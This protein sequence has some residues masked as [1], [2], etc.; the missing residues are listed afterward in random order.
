MIEKFLNEF[1]IIKGIVQV[2]SNSGQEIDIMSK[3]TK[4]IMLFDPLS[5][6]NEK[7]RELYPSYK[8][9]DVALGSENKDS[10]LYVA[11]NQGESSS[12]LKP[13]KHVDFYPQITFDK[14]INISIKKFKTIIDDEKI[15]V[16]KYN[17][18]ISDTQGYDLEVLKGF[19]DYIN[20]FNLIILEYINSELYENNASLDDIKNYLS[21]I[22]FNLVSTFDENL[23]AG[24]A[25]FIKK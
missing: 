22:G 8:I 7:L 24:N 14:K 1:K 18:I 9:F 11:S 19:E 15:D 16:G 25:V 10:Y 21:P 3:H 17:V 23:G 13:K 2:G 12:I 4:N 5:D 6:I 20:N